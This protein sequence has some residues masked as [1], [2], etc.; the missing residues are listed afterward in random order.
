M[1]DE[2]SSITRQLQELEDRL[3]SYPDFD[4]SQIDDRINELKDN[5]LDVISGLVNGVE[6]CLVKLGAYPDFDG[7]RLSEIH[8]QISDNSLA[9]MIQIIDKL[10]EY[11]ND[12]KLCPDPADDIAALG[13]VEFADSVELSELLVKIEEIESRTWPDNN[14]ASD[15]E[16]IEMRVESWQKLHKNVDSLVEFLEKIAK[17]AEMVEQ[18]IFSEEQA[19]EIFNNL[20][21]ECGVC[22]LCG[23][24]C[25]GGHGK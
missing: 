24:E 10:E 9:E 5:T 23:E 13:R 1:V 16:E 17:L 8:T 20:L 3:N 6:S 14:W 11:D 19:T 7:E 12:L 18:K 21:E 15:I 4:S 25:G 22:P 2:L